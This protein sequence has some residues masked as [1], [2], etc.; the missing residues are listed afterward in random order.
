M[1]TLPRFCIY[2][3]T[4]PPKVGIIIFIRKEFTAFPRTTSLLPIPVCSQLHTQFLE[5]WS[6]FIRQQV[7]KYSLVDHNLRTCNFINIKFY[8]RVKS[9]INL[10]TV[11]II[12]QLLPFPFHLS[13][14]HCLHPI[15]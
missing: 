1:E 10:N 4:K 14:L 2:D 5:P 11:C 3:A 7:Y 13:S 12:H 8:L 6:K 15:P 9:I